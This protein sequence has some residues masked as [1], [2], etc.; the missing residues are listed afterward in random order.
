[1]LQEWESAAVVLGQ[2]SPRLTRRFQRWLSSSLGI[3]TVTIDVVLGSIEAESTE[4]DCSTVNFT[5][6]RHANGL[7]LLEEPSLVARHAS[8]RAFCCL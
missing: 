7:F 5:V 3:F 1:M 4:L 2:G 8:G 6:S